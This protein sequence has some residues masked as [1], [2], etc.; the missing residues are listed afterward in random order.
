MNDETVTNFLTEF[1]QSRSKTIDYEK[2]TVD[3]DMSKSQ[4]EYQNTKQSHIEYE[5]MNKENTEDLDVTDR[6]YVSHPRI[7]ETRKILEQSMKQNE[8]PPENIHESM[9]PISDR[10]EYRAHQKRQ[11]YSKFLDNHHEGKSKSFVEMIED[12]EQRVKQMAPEQIFRQVQTQ[13]SHSSYQENATDKS[14]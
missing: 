14:L 1:E 10:G 12:E 6:S 4:V 11:T 7:V 3:Y 13:V 8:Q 9:S 5:Q 2:Q